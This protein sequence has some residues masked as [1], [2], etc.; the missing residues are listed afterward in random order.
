MVAAVPTE[1]GFAVTSTEAL[2]QHWS[3]GRPGSAMYDVSADGERILVVEN[4]G[5]D[6]DAQPSIHVIQNWYE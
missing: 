5:D 4:V 3:L 1:N 6:V 2:F